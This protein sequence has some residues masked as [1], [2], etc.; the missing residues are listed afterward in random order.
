MS[1]STNLRSSLS[2][3]AW[4][5]AW[6]QSGL[7]EDK[8]VI[9]HDNQPGPATRHLYAALTDIQYDYAPDP[10]GWPCTIKV[11]S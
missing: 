11:G 2:A 6:L 1:R 5:G 9:I 8:I 4:P 3:R 10:C 7:R